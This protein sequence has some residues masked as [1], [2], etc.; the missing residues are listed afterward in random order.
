ML[1]DPVGSHRRNDLESYAGKEAVYGLTGTAILLHLIANLLSR[2][3][4]KGSMTIN[5]RGGK[6]GGPFSLRIKMK[7]LRH[8][9]YDYVQ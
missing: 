6:I 1:Q 5:L 7:R 9:Q 3:N 2:A 8:L 4:A